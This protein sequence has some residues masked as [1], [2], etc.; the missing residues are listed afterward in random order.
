MEGQQMDVV[1]GVSALLLSVSLSGSLSVLRLV[2]FTL[3]LA[4]ACGVCSLP[5]P[6]PYLSLLW[7]LDPSCFSLGLLYL[8]IS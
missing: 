4:E 6:E 2:L 3:L 5:L 7:D 8:W 1:L